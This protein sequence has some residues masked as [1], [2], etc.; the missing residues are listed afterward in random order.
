MT[1]ATDDEACA[2][3]SRVAQRAKREGRSLERFGPRSIGENSPR[4]Q[5]LR[6]YLK[7]DGS[8]G[9]PDRVILS[10]ESM[11]LVEIE[12]QHLGDEADGDELWQW[13]NGCERRS[14]RGLRSPRLAKP[15]HIDQI[16]AA[17]ME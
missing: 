17:C 15:D 14:G 1:K 2:P 5:H 11:R 8:I 3:L 6:S 16:T 4:P 12:A 7:W 9:G 10:D 13:E